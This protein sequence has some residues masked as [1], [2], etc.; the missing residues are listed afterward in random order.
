MGHCCDKPDHVVCGGIWD[1]ETWSRGEHYKQ[2]LT[3]H[4]NMNIEE[5]SAGSH[6]DYRH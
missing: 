2:D 1:H 6:V 4:P 3:G 5:S